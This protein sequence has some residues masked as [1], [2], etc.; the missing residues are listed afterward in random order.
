MGMWYMHDVNGWWM[1]VGWV[2]DVL[3]WVGIAV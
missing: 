1:A 3:I 2:A